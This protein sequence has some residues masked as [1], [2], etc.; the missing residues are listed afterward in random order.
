MKKQH[1]ELEERIHQLTLDMV[2][3]RSVVGTTDEIAMSE[4]VYQI[5]SKID[6]WK[7]NP[8]LLYRLPF[9]NDPLGRFSVVASLKGEKCSSDKTVV[10]IGHT[11]TVGISDYGDLKDLA[12]QPDKLI[13]ALKNVT[14]S[15][16]AKKDLESANWLFGRGILDMKCGVAIIIAIMEHISREI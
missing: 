4:K 14:I 16:D 10:M 6:Y 3:C 9:I 7:E 13:E 12:T 15:N 11:D 5:F 1:L 2:G 8:Q